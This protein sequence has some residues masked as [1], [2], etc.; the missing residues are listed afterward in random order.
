MYEELQAEDAAI[1][2]D[3]VPRLSAFPS[4]RKHLIPILQ[5]IQERHQFLP[6]EAI[7]LVARHL[8]L[9][10]CEVYG[11]ATFYNQFRFN[12]PEDIRSRSAW[13]PRAT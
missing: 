7:G 4:K 10:V 2:A 3:I 9:S 1:L 8:G 11:V 12:P 13:A 5:M 6:H